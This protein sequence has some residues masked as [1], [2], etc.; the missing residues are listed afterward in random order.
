CFL[1]GNKGYLRFPSIVSSGVVK[2]V[3]AVKI[4]DHVPHY[5]GAGTDFMPEKGRGDHGSII[6]VYRGDKVTVNRKR[7]FF[8]GIGIG[9]I[10]PLPPKAKKILIPVAVGK[11]NFI[12]CG[13]KAP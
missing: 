11:I 1:G 8:S 12:I 4:P 6:H 9:I 2:K 10:I 13:K 5:P 3:V 7:G